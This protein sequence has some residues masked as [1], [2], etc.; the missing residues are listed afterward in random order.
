MCVRSMFAEA[1]RGSLWAHSAA[2]DVTMLDIVFLALG[3]GA[4]ALFGVFAALL[5]R[6]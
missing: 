4:F 2:R 3:L 6:L 1:P 5:R